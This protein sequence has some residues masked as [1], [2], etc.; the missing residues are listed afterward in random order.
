MDQPISPSRCHWHDADAEAQC[1]LCERPLCDRCRK[2]PTSSPLC[3]EHADVRVYPNGWV[4][5]YQ[6]AHEI[7]A[8]LIAEVLK[9]QGIDAHVLSQKDHVY[10]VGVGQLSVLRLIVPAGSYAA[11]R[12]A[13]AADFGVEVAPPPTCPVCLAPYVEGQARCPGCGI[14]LTQR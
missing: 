11:A 5:V 13:L 7:Q 6:S 4:E 3:P 12:A 1:I 8:H 9:G 14:V 2:G 10:V